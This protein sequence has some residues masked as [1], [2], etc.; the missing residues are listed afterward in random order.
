MSQVIQRLQDLKIDVV[1]Q[2]DRA[3]S[4]VQNGIALCW[5]TVTTTIGQGLDARLLGEADKWTGS[6]NA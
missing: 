6:G 4:K 5:T 1:K 3:L 2:L